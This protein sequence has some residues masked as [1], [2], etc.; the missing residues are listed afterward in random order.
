MNLTR[1]FWKI[2]QKG[3]GD[4]HKREFFMYNFAPNLIELENGNLAIL[5]CPQILSTSTSM[6]APNMNDQQHMVSTTTLNVGPVMAF[7]PN[8][9]GQRFDYAIVPRK[10]SLTRAASSRFRRHPG[11][12]ITGNHAFVFKLCSIQF[13]QRNC[14]HLQRQ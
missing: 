3:G 10:I 2:Y 11:R 1:N 8:K 13:R 4:K 7:Y 12:A 9:N 14:D 6:S 5:G